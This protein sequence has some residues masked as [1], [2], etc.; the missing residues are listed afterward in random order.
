MIDRLDHLVLTVRNLDETCRFY[1]GMLGMEVV[2]SPAGRLSLH[3][4]REKINLHLHGQEFEPKAAHVMPGSADLCF[5]TTL[6]IEEVA[7]Q[8]TAKGAAIIEG[9]IAR[10]GA[11]G[12]MMSI[13]L[14]DPDGNLVEIA[15]YDEELAE[16]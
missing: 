7:A 14:R 4:G 15:H 13:Y 2:T 11:C 5:V 9:P 16:G 12:P 3:F 10:T 1:S 6:P 8:L